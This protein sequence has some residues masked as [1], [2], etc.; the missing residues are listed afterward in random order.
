MHDENSKPQANSVVIWN[1]NAA[2]NW[3]LIFTPAFGAYVQ[4]LN[5][6]RLGHPD[7]AAQSR[8]WFRIAVGMLI[9]YIVLSFVMP[10]EK[11]A[12]G[13]ARGL[14]LI[15]LFSWYFASARSQAKYVKEKFGSQ[16]LRQSWGK[17]IG[18]AA[19]GM[20]GYFVAVVL[21]GVLYAFVHHL[22]R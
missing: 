11:V 8:R 12:D 2:A 14:G 21:A 9:L 22:A 15:F 7:L 1:P 3:S 4:M 5:W 10:D 17:A 18:I 13:A 19:L 16:Y 6:Q 20:L